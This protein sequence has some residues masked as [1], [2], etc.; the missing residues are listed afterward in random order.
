MQMIES[1]WF[2][3]TF[4]DIIEGTKETEDGEQAPVQ[5]DTFSRAIVGDGLHHSASRLLLA[6]MGAAHGSYFSVNSFI[7]EAFLCYR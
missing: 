7:Q 1:A 2:K 4:R 6:F 5:R 3:E